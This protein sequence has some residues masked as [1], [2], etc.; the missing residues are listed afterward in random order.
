MLPFRNLLKPG[1]R[2]TWTDQLD[3]LFQESKTL[4]INEIHR[5][6]EIYDKTKPTC[7][8]TDWSREGI[9]FWLFQKHCGCNSSRPFCCKS[10]WKIT[11]VGSRFTSGAES[12]YAPVE[13]EALAV[14]DALEKARH[15]VLGCPNLTVAVDHKPL[16]KTFGDRSLDAIPNPRLLNLKEK[17]LR[18]QFRIVHI[19]GVRNFAADAVSRHP[20]GDPIQLHLPDDSSVLSDILASVRTSEAEDSE[21]CVQFATPSQLI[22]SVTW[23]DLRLS[24]ASDP[25]LIKLIDTIED[26]FPNRREDLSPDL[27]PYFQFR[28][29]L[30]TFDGIIL[31]NDRVVIPQS[32]RDSILTALHSAHQGVSQMCSRAESSFFWPGM[33]PAIIELR[34]RCSSCNRMAPSQPS[35]PPT[36]PVP[37]AY[38]FQQIAADF[39]SFRGKNYLV[40]VD[41][42][43]GWPIVEQASGGSAGLIAALRR[44]FVTYGI[45]E[46]LSSD[47]GPEFTA[48]GTQSFLRNWGVNHRLSAVANPHSNCRAEIGV[49]TV[50]RLLTGNT[51][52]NGSLDTDTFQRAI[53]QYRD[54]P[55]RDTHL[56]PAMCLFGRP[57]RDFIPIHP[58]K[59]KPHI[60]WRETIQA[61]E[62]ALRNRHMK[63][64]ERLSEHTRCLPPLVMG[65][66]VRIQN[67]V[68]PHPTKWDKTGVIIEVR[69][70]DQYVVR[71]DGSGRVTLRN[72]KFLRKYLPVI[73]RSPIAMLPNKHAPTAPEH[74][75]VPTVPDRHRQYTSDQPSTKLAAPPTC[76]SPASKPSTPDATARAPPVD[77]PSTPATPAIQPRRYI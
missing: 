25:T 34:A 17:S 69:Q 35:A 5:G 40:V 68:G 32:L 63:V 36:P 23:D 43:S 26:G 45:S 28:E 53:L 58:G 72:R 54:T 77:T 47:G 1:T 49:K 11:L 60:T 46:Q 8:V 64:S 57:I 55:D 65:D 19:P 33:T 4:I 56:S 61:R 44:I 51:D 2:F 20:A 21:V 75:T 10:G 29:K 3:R 59:Y 14:V 74:P 52:P 39:F 24:T 48:Q 6:V 13:G 67:Q 31:Y 30:T 37:P 71:V 38:P 73:P 41:R 62:E 16:L 70:F 7:L 12:R 42:Y 15:F 27:Q 66:C 76:A 22:K 50:K 18:F 9:G